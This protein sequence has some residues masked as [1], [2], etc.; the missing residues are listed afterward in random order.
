MAAMAQP[1]TQ[2]ETQPPTPGAKDFWLFAYGSLM[3][4]ADF[5]HA[6][7][8]PARLY[9]YH[10]A[11]CLYSFNYRGTRKNPGL[12]LGLDRGGSCRGLAF[13]ILGKD[14][15]A[16]MDHLHARETSDGEYHLRWL[17]LFLKGRKAPVTGAAFVVN[18]ANEAY[19][20]R[21]PLDETAR[22]IAEGR[23]NRG[24]CADYLGNTVAHLREMG[25][26]DDGLERVLRKLEA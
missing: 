15:D 14:R 19:A 11:L 22:M 4:N 7:T 23:G 24:A 5:A 6:E 26:R 9:G 3:W 25:I 1:Q 20:G 12:V 17:K 21:R 2:T 8:R 16:V 18:H 13:R 10:R